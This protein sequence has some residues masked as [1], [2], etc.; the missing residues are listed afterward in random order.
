MSEIERKICI[1]FLKAIGFNV[2]SKIWIRASW[3][4]QYVAAPPSWKTYQRDD[5]KIYCQYVFCGYITDLGF[6]L[7]RCVYGGRNPSGNTIWKPTAKTHNDGFKL[8][9]NLSKIGATVCFYPNQPTIGISNAQVMSC[10]SIFYEIDNF[11]VFYQQSAIENLKQRTGLTPAA[12]VYTGG[13]SLHVYFR[14]SQP[15]TPEQWLLLNRKLTIIQSSDPAIC[16]LA[17]AM[18]LPGLYR[19]KVVNGVLCSPVPI[20]L[21][22]CSECQYSP[23]LIDKLLDST[24]LFPYGLEEA[25]WRKWVQLFHKEQAGEDV[26]PEDAL[27]HSEWNQPVI[28]FRSKRRNYPRIEVS[29]QSLK[30]TRKLRNSLLIPLSICLTHDDRNLLSKGSYLGNRNNCG[31][32]LARNLLGTASLLNEKGIAYFPNPYD[33]F[34]QYSSRCN[35]P[36]DENER[37]T[38]WKSASSK[39]AYPSRDYASIIKSIRQWKRYHL[40]A[41]I[42]SSLTIAS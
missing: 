31:Y 23:N 6:T 33:L 9:Q 42:R 4:H 7:T 8:A 28:Y 13:K 32:K 41:N 21:E 12:V 22:Q 1:K 30:K 38:I 14:S 20:T 39:P 34:K 27:N 16:N 15:L 11:S 2:G 35:P 18:R 3:N 36:I 5:K 25:R 10:H 17:R 26:N 29:C 19:Y 40:P 24:E 37:E